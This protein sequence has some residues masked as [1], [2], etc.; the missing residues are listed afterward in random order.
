MK[1]ANTWDESIIQ[2][3]KQ[4]YAD[5]STGGDEEWNRKVAEILSRKMSTKVVYLGLRQEYEYN[6]YRYSVE[7]NSNREGIHLLS[8]SEDEEDKHV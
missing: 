5:I 2:I 4:G 8:Q 3:R 1:V 6:V 7:V